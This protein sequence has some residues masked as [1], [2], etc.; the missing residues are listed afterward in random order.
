MTIRL[1]QKV[2]IVTGAGRGVGR[3]YA[4]ELAK[5]GAKVVV[6]DLGGA[7][8]GTGRSCQPA[9]EVV[10]EIRAA[11]GV[12]VADF[13]DVAEA[14]SAAA[15]VQTALDHFGTVDILINNPGILSDSSFFKMPLADFE[16]VI[17]VHLLGTVYVTKAAFPIMQERKY[18][19]IVLAT[20][21]AGLYGN[22]GQTN[23][24][25]AK[26]GIVGFM[27]SLKEEGS[28]YHILVNTVAP[29]AASRLGADVF[30]AAL[31]EQM[32]PEWVAALVVYLC[33]DSCQ[34]SGNIVVA[35][36]GHYAGVQLRESAGIRFDLEKAI[37]PEAIRD[38]FPAIIGMEQSAGFSNSREA[39]VKALGP[40]AGK[41]P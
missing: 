3:H 11:G 26:L 5:R 16:T 21:S 25:A 31:M 36:M 30:P 23:Y 17:K 22:F 4:L 20:S 38:H 39:F 29:L 37:S 12:A 14:E 28:R 2:A 35:G 27:N 9:E 13:H 18:G 7:G 32:K 41:T 24:S 19:R 10:Q 34:D 15:I 40:L 33:S 8:D 6:N 1:D